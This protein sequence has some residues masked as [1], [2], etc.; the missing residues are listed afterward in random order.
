MT[1][2]M[3]LG[4]KYLGKPV[5]DIYGRNLGRI[6]GLNA[7]VKNEVTQ[8]EVELGSGEFFSCPSSLILIKG[9]S[10]SYVYQW[11]I[12]AQN[13]EKAMTLAL[14]RLYALDELLRIGEIPR[15][16]YEDFKKYHESSLSQLK[17]RRRILVDGLKERVNRL[18]SQIKELQVFL[19]SLKM[20]H[21]TG[22][23]D[24]GTYKDMCAAIQSGLNRTSSEK[25]DI[26]AT[27]TELMQLDLKA[28]PPPP[29]PKPL[30]EAKP[31]AP[32]NP[33]TVP[34]SQP[35]KSPSPSASESSEVKPQKP[36]V[37]QIEG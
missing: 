21:S 10:V 27:I 17:D 14:K 33:V 15:D 31:P 18:N 34:D 20:Q 24:E 19:A 16:I 7:D 12:D 2:S 4:K 22:E 37:V 13:I 36:I 1:L 23:L 6:V 29:A 35:G 5:F 30:Q 32:Q 9:D 11:K 25:E 28:T 8:I 26:E 3:E